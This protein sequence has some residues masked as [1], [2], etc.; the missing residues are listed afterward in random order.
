MGRRPGLGAHQLLFLKSTFA[1]PACFPAS[2][3]WTTV[4]KSKGS[5][6]RGT[7]RLGTATSHLLLTGGT[8]L[9]LWASGLGDMVRVGAP[10]DP[11]REVHVDG[12]WGI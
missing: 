5:G 11:S 9:A 3:P 12:K 10:R 8:H 2:S 6:V 7:C 4:L 1:F